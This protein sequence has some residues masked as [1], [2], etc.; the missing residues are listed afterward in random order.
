MSAVLPRY[1]MGLVFV[2]FWTAG[3]FAASQ[4]APTAQAA[5]VSASSVPASAEELPSIPEFGSEA[6]SALDRALLRLWQ[7]EIDAYHRLTEDPPEIHD[8]AARFMRLVQASMLPTPRLMGPKSLPSLGESL[9][10]KG[11][12]DVLIRAYL[13]WAWKQDGDYER[14]AS[15]IASALKEWDQSP[16]STEMRRAALTTYARML[17]ELPSLPDDLIRLQFDVTTAFRDYFN[18]RLEDETITEDLERAVYFE[19][20]RLCG[21]ITIH[22]PLTS[23]LPFLHQLRLEKTT[24]WLR[25]MMSALM[26]QRMAWS[27]R[28]N[29]FAHEVPPDQWR[30]FYEYSEKAVEELQKAIELR[31]DYPEAYA[32]MIGIS[33]STGRY[34]T[35]REWFEKAVA[36]QFDHIPAYYAYLTSLY[37]RWG[38]DLEQML[39]FGRECARTRRYDT[40]VPYLFVIAI[41]KIDEEMGSNHDIWSQPGIFE[42]AMEVLDGL[43]KEPARDGELA[44]DLSRR[45]LATAK[46]MIAARARRVDDF[47]R[48]YET[49]QGRPDEQ[50]MYLWY[51]QPTLTVAEYLAWSSPARPFLEE[52]RTIHRIPWEQTTEE[53]IARLQELLDQAVLHA[54]EAPAK[55]FC[56]ALRQSAD[57]RLAFRSG[58]W[59]EPR[60][61]EDLFSWFTICGHWKRENERTLVGKADYKTGF[62]MGRLMFSPP[63]PVEI[64]LEIEAAVPR[65]A[66]YAFGIGLREP[67]SNPDGP[68]DHRFL[69]Q[70]GSNEAVVYMNNDRKVAP[71]KVAERNLLKVQLADQ[72]VVLWVNGERCLDIRDGNFH[73]SV[74]YDFGAFTSI[75]H[76]ENFRIANLRIRKWA[77]AESTDTPPGE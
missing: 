13:G 39:E 8:Q 54:E 24:P 33:M 49:L 19:V 7:R 74:P 63:P 43:E 3:R 15:L 62:A 25:S 18:A 45:Y 59:I 47:R 69:V 65:G 67:Q 64:E 57:W 5:N 14:A 44:V 77:D 16:Y 66:F 1:V 31:P 17:A 46:L 35:P 26:H 53:Q 30:L 36:A 40:N 58:E 50:V 61:D 29:R 9:L 76:M 73:P 41:E 27:A 28:G 55:A 11:S 52:A 71:A 60:F 12:H 37:P 20:G 34:G 68:H 6:A 32:A 4:T 51:R 22:G 42:Q 48:I 23:R 21:N 72:H 2:V 38:G 70:Y 10:E 75:L 56:A